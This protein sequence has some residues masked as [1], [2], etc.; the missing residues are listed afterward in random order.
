MKYVIYLIDNM[1]IWEN[2]SLNLT[3]EIKAC[4]YFYKP[5]K[6]YFS[7]AVCRVLEPCI[8]VQSEKKEK[9]PCY[10]SACRLKL[11]HGAKVEHVIKA[12]VSRRA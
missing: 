4:I 8:R 11:A 10:E 6:F 3:H 1:Q 2:H 9:T 5:H 7:G 12:N